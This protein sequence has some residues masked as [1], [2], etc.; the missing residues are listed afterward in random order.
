MRYADEPYQRGRRCGQAPQVAL[1][2][3]GGW[4]GMRSG[5]GDGE[6]EVAAEDRAQVV[7]RGLRNPQGGQ[8]GDQL[9]EDERAF[10]FAQGR[11]NA[12]EGATAEAERSRGA[13][14]DAEYV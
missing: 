5:G 1:P 14:P 4:H 3:S 12:V 13:A 8:P 2:G 7:D 11:T 6:T 10:E 9:L